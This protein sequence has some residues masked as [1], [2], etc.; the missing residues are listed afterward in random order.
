MSE[1]CI[2]EFETSGIY[3]H[4]DRKWRMGISQDDHKWLTETFGM[5]AK[6]EEKWNRG[7]GQWRYLGSQPLQCKLTPTKRS[8]P[9][10]VRM[11]FR[12]KAQAMLFKL[13]RTGDI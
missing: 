6:N 9:Y 5:R 3:V 1:E 7:L 8:Y 2:L 11:M 12:T 10:K 13:A 4:P